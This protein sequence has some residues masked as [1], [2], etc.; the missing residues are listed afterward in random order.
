MDS[1]W[2]VQ[3]SLSIIIRVPSGTGELGVRKVD[4]ELGNWRSMDGM[5]SLGCISQFPNG[6]SLGVLSNGATAVLA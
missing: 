6:L 3:L 5:F 1:Y 4:H 2:P